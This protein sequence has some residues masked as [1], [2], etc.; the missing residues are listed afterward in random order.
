MI[1]T[2][3]G[4]S[5][6]NTLKLS[7]ALEYEIRKLIECGVS[8]FYNG[9]YGDFDIVALKVVNKLKSE[10]PHIKSY[11]VLAYL[12]DKH[13]ERLDNIAKHYSAETFYPF[14]Q[15]V[16]PRFAILKRNEYMIDSSDFVIS[17]AGFGGSLTALDYA[18]RKKKTII[19]V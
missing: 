19:Y 17:H 5:S 14:E 4:A 15:K 6:C 8:Q 9:G 7:D 10:C 18:A 1:C 12:I 16:I 2:F 11:I 3:I 13:V